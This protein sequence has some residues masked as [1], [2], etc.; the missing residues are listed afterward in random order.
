MFLNTGTLSP[1]TCTV[2][3]ERTRRHGSV[4]CWIR[5]LLVNPETFNDE[6]T[7][8]LFDKVVNS[9]TFNEDTIVVLF[10][11]VVNPEIFS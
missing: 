10:D 2:L 7:F 5:P 9:E 11:K 1:R 4:L 3:R 8:V 6:T